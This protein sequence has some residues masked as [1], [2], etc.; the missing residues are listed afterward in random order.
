MLS[1]TQQENENENRSRLKKEHRSVR[2]H[3]FISDSLV[4]HGP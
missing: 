1:E 3:T 4:T 2:K